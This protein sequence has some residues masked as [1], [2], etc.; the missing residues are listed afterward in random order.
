MSGHDAAQP[1]RCPNCSHP[2]AAAPRPRFCAHC[3]QATTLHP[4]TL[5]EFVH[6]FV[7]HHVAL[8]GTLWRTLGTLLLRC[9]LRRSACSMR[10]CRR[11]HDRVDGRRRVVGLRPPQPMRSRSQSGSPTERLPAK[12]I[13]TMRAP[14]SAQSTSG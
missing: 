2:L 11:Q 13:H 5:L 1:T 7:G 3:G 6:E 14:P 12:S 8:E 9:A 4:P 10:D